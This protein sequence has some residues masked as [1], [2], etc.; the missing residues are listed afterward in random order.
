MHEYQEKKEQEVAEIIKQQTSSSS[1]KPSALEVGDAQQVG[2]A[3]G[4]GGEQ[5]ASDAKAE[6]PAAVGPVADEAPAD[7]GT[8][9]TKKKKKKTKSKCGCTIS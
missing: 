4:A 7:S 1:L 2:V 8:D 5:Q 6:E 3:V 9:D